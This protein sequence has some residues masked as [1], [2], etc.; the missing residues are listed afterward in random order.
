M[1]TAVN[2]TTK[3]CPPLIGTVVFEGFELLDT[4]GP[5]E[6]FL[7]LPDLF[8]HTMLAEKRGIVKSAQGPSGL[9]E[10]SLEK[11]RKVDILLIPGGVGTRKC[12]KNPFF[13]REIKRLAESASYVC[14]VCTG[15]GILA[16]ADLLNDKK[17][18]TNKA[19]WKWATSQSSSV[20]WIPQARWVEDG[21]YFT[22]AGVSAGMDMALA[23]IGKM[24][25]TEKAIEIANFAEYDWHQNSE[26]DPFAEIYGLA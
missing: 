23:L 1:V 7:M 12:V 17:A 8:A 21:K 15:A 19:A 18:T 25:G 13:V 2:P 6:L 5:L 4:Y 14:S 24:Y 3:S 9:A 20:N 16:Y 22:S 11:C 10:Q 26:W